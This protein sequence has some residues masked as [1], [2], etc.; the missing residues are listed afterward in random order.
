MH[1]QHGI[2]LRCSAGAI[3]HIVGQCGTHETGARRISQFN[4]R[5]VLT[6][7]AQAWLQAMQDQLAIHRLVLQAQSECSEPS[8]AP[9]QFA[10]KAGLQLHVYLDE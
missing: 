2:A 1:E 5:H 7:L 6:Q 3:A 4:E 9:L 10:P 8:S